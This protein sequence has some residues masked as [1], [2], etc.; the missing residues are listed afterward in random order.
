MV[1]VIGGIGEPIGAAGYVHGYRGGRERERLDDQAGAPVDFDAG[2]RDLH[3]APEADGV[4]SYT[5]F[6]ATATSPLQ[7]AS[8][9]RDHNV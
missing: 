6:K 5:F 2:V 7:W 8:S 1:D 4:F 9:P 3:R